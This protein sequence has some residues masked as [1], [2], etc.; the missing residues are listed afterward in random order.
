MVELHR[1]RLAGRASIKFSCGALS[2]LELPT[3]QFPQ[4]GSLKPNALIDDKFRGEAVCPMCC[5]DGG[6]SF[7]RFA[8]VIA[9]DRGN[10]VHFFKPAQHRRL[11][12]SHSLQ[13]PTPPHP[14]FQTLVLFA[15]TFL[16]TSPLSIVF[17][18]LGS[19]PST[20]TRVLAHSA[21]VVVSQVDRRREDGLF[22]P[23]AAH[24]E[25]ELW[26]VGRVACYGVYALHSR[27][28][29]VH[30]RSGPYVWQPWF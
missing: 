2:L 22:P 9:L 16:Q 19:L 24:C 10:T 4:H 6:V 14:F 18:G 26:R 29:A 5:G 30:R 8:F 11:P 3:L 27:S 7:V 23:H 13:Q 25:P 28:T 12:Y 17:R 15:C 20:A 21:R 1:S